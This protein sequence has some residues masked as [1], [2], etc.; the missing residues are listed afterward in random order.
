MHQMDPSG[1]LPPDLE[2]IF[3]LQVPGA[4]F[5]LAFITGLRDGGWSLES[6]EEAEGSDGILTLTLRPMRFGATQYAGLVRVPSQ[7]GALE[8]RSGDSA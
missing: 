3:H 1:T 8:P 6:I 4:A 7:R 2:G 5:G